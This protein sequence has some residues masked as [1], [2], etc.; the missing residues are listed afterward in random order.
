MK[1]LR[2]MPDIFFE[3]N[4]K[5]GCFYHLLEKKIQYWGKNENEIL[6]LLINDNVSVEE[7]KNKYSHRSKA[8]NLLINYL[9]DKKLI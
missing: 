4:E 6:K 5:N 9:R 2:L 3:S 8:V 1:Y 7:V